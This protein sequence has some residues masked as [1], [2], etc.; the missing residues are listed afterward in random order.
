MERVAL[1]NKM[2]ANLKEKFHQGDESTLLEFWRNIEQEGT[3]LDDAEKILRG[4]IDRYPNNYEILVKLCNMLFWNKPEDNNRTHELIQKCE[5]IL[6][7]CMVDDIRNTA[8]YFLALGYDRI[9]EH[10]KAV[11]AANR[12]PRSRVTKEIVLTSVYR[13]EE[14]RIQRQKNVF[15]CMDQIFAEIFNMAREQSDPETT[16]YYNNI[17]IRMIDIFFENKDYHLYHTRL[18]FAYLWIAASYVKLGNFS[19]AIENLRNAVVHVK[20]Y[21]KLVG[22]EKY[23]SRC[24]DLCTF[25]KGGK[26]YDC[27]AAGQLCIQLTGKSFDPIRETPE[28]KE[29]L[30]QLKG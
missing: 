10:E 11:D 25:V 16:L 29:I 22:G 9:N 18:Q 17:L 21:D 13:G 6:K 28:F 5:L 20:A 7:N 24:F 12:L 15:F 1:E 26:P 8:L 14:R 2:I 19:K 30:E 3:P 4:A 23:T 27:S